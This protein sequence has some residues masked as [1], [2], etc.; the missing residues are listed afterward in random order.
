[1][2][3]T[4]SSIIIA[5]QARRNNVDAAKRTRLQLVTKAEPFQ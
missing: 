3:K 2:E 5:K 1:M 4:P